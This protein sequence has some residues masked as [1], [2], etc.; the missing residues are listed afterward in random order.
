MRACCTAFVLGWLGAHAAAAAAAGAADPADPAADAPCAFAPFDAHAHRPAVVNVH[1]PNSG[2]SRALW[3]LAASVDSLLSLPG[4]AAAADDSST[5]PDS[6][7]AAAAHFLFRGDAAAVA[8]LQ[9]LFHARLARLAPPQRRGWCGRLHFQDDAVQDAAAAAPLAT[10]PHWPSVLDTATLVGLPDAATYDCQR[11]DAR[12][13]WLGW[14]FD[15]SDVFRNPTPLVHV[16]QGVCD[17]RRL[18]AKDS[19]TGQLALL[20][21]T[22]DCSFFQQVKTAQTVLNASGV[23]VVSGERQTL[24]DMNCH[25]DAECNDASLHIPATMVD[26][27][28]GQQAVQALQHQQ[29][30]RQ[31]PQQ[32]PAAVR[33][34][35]AFATRETPTTLN[36]AVDHDGRFVQSWGGTGLGAGKVDGNQGDKSALLYPRMQ[37]LGW[38]GE[39][40]AYRRG[41]APRVAAAGKTH[42]TTVLP[43]G[44][45]LRPASGDCYGAAPYECGPAA[46]VRVPALRRG[47]RRKA[48]LEV[49]LSCSASD[50]SDPNDVNDIQCP[51]WDHVVSARVCCAAGGACDALNTGAELGRWITPF[52]RSVGHWLSD[53]SDLAPFLLA[54]GSTCNVTAF[55]APWE[56]NQG[57]IP[58]TLSMNLLLDDE[59]TTGAAAA[60][61]AAAN[62]EPLRLLR[63]WADVT[64]ATGGISEAFHW[65]QFDQNYTGR[66]SP[67]K[68]DGVGAATSMR[69]FA[70]ITGHGNDNHGC[71]E[72]CATAHKFTVTHAGK[73]ATRW[74]N[75]TLPA[76]DQALGCAKQTSTGVV[77]NEFG[78]WLYGRDGWCNGRDVFLWRSDPIDLDGDGDG[79]GDSSVTI[80]YDAMWCS[81]AGSCVSPNPGP[82]STWSQSAPVIQISVFAILYGP[83]AAAQSTTATT[84]SSSSASATSPASPN[85]NLA[86]ARAIVANLTLDEKVRLLQGNVSLAHANGYVGYVQGVPGVIPDLRMNDGPE[87]FR[88]KKAG[89]STQWPSGLTAAHSWNRSLLAEWGA[90]MGQEFYLK[91]AN[92]FFGPGANV[93]RLSNGGRSFEYLSGEDPFLGHQLIQPVVKGVQ[94]QKV[95]ANAKHYLDNN[96]EGLLRPGSPAKGDRHSTSEIVDERTQHEIYYPPFEGAFE[97]GVG[98]YMCANNLINGEYACQNGA[99]Q[100][101]MLK[102]G[103]GFL[104]FICSDYDGTR[105]TVDAALGGLDIAMPGPP[106]RP[107][108]FGG[109]MHTALAKGLLNESVV[110]DKAVRIVYALAATGALD[111]DPA[112]RAQRTADRDVTSEAHVSLARRMA[113]E[114]VVLLKN[115]DATLPLAQAAAAD[116][117]RRGGASGGGLKIAVIGAAGRAPGAIFGGD[118]SGK[119]T[120][121]H[122]VDVFEALEAAAGDVRKVTFSDGSGDPAAV[123]ALA[124]AADVAVVVLAQTSTEGHDRSTIALPQDELVA[125]AARGG[126]AKIV[127]VAVNPGPFLT[128]SWADAADAIVDMGLPGEQ[129]GNGLVDVLFGRVN[130]SGKLPHTLPNRWNEMNM[131][132]R[133][134]PGVAPDNKS[135]TLPLCGFVPPSPPTLRF[136]PCAPTKAFYEEKLLVGY[137]WYFAKGVTPAFP[138]GHGLSYTTFKYSGLAVDAGARRVSLQVAN[139]GAVAGAEVV[140][141]YV[142][143]PDAAG[144][145]FRQLRGFE[146]VHL[147]PGEARDVSFTLSTRWLSIWVPGGGGWQLVTGSHSV[148]VGSSSTDIRLSGVLE[149]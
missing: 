105:S 37:F 45:S 119:V 50:G 67:V 74:K 2:F 84:T 68:L 60:V 5:S 51:Q 144:E 141:L 118:G 104:G 96:Q 142:R 149:V 73:S 14:S 85:P 126:K 114:A 131:T 83:P 15:P 61:A 145:P 41:L 44:T 22:D 143:Y 123:N 86:R 91:G 33:V 8:S 35:M 122:A 148:M 54:P 76:S 6:A 10:A 101:G 9:A 16:P 107:D 109:M 3:G 71:G 108:F 110:D 75:N 47:H 140:Q 120:P 66:F 116:D 79:D 49:A 92:V 136:Q 18:P 97:A 135:G 38:A 89:T 31:Q 138:F 57:S 133:Q 55:V 17:A 23:V 19:L 69:L 59:A 129:E 81:A 90:A 4:T 21:R 28:C 94:S 132:A 11:L 36:Y 29:R 1:A 106:V 32:H 134:Y 63:P 125:V 128:D 137:R 80:E 117:D 93:A 102:D 62:E 72:F 40:L 103:T 12:Y 13:D 65:V 121:K 88:A 127:V 130:P 64:T 98:S 46:V 147:A 77:P 113:S 7:A 139:T 20:D 52:S 87:G 115:R 100:N 111:E 30:K 48:S 43:P 146:K 34:S 42:A 99:V 78:T 112:S 27:R 58:W 56:G 26:H 39:F 82:P 70:Y 24:L 25:G 53:V 124:Q 95:V